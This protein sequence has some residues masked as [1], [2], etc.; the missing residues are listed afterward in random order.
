MKPNIDQLLSL[1]RAILQIVGTVLV[2]KSIVT[3]TDWTTYSGAILMALPIVWGLY[4]HTDTA[5]IEAAAA[6]PS[7]AGKDAAF[8]GVSDTA[9]LKAVEA[10]PEV[11]QI[12]VKRS[13]TDG[14]AAAAADPDRPKVVTTPAVTAT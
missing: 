12:N 8:A 10:M 2:T 1:V 4:A 6:I 3:T 11:T 14:V 13:A 5:K 9:K 7:G